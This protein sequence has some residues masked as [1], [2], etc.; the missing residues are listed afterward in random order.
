[1][2]DG[3]ARRLPRIAHRPRARNRPAQV[4]R[5]LASVSPDPTESQTPGP[6]GAAAH[7]RLRREVGV[8]GAAMMGLGSILGTGIFVSIGI[9]AGAAGPSVVFAIAL[10]AVVA[11]LNGLSSAQLAANHP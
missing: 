7:T 8:F 9:A 2:R 5:G 3:S 1:L 10:A 11:T 4:A 6:A